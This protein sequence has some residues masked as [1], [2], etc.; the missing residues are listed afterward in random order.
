[1]LAFSGDK[2]YR[3]LAH[4][5]SFFMTCRVLILSGVFLMNAPWPLDGFGA[6]RNRP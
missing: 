1:M 2:N 5:K 6:K 3:G 4:M